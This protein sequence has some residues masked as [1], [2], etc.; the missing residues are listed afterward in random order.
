MEELVDKDSV[1]LKF[2]LQFTNSENVDLDLYVQIPSGAI[3]YYKYWI[4]Y[5][6]FCVEDERIQV[7]Y[8][9]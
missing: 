2:N 6:E 3:I 8:C 7:Q 4:D 9:G 5:F 1:I